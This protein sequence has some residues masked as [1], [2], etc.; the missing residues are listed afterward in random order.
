MTGRGQICVTVTGRERSKQ[1]RSVCISRDTRSEGSYTGL[2]GLAGKSKQL[3][4]TQG[5]DNSKK[6]VFKS[7]RGYRAE[8]RGSDLCRGGYG[9]ISVRCSFF[10]NTHSNLLGG[11]YPCTIYLSTSQSLIQ[12]SFQNSCKIKNN[13]DDPRGWTICSRSLR[14]SVAEQEANTELS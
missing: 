2:G 8:R 3:K 11:S 12:L 13:F 5:L 10:L 7:T 6:G 4:K 1:W 14:N 9:D